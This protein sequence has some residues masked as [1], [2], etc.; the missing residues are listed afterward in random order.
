MVTV[1]VDPRAKRRPASSTLGA[2]PVLPARIRSLRAPLRRL[3]TAPAGRRAKTTGDAHQVRPPAVKLG[4][5]SLGWI[6]ENGPGHPLWLTS[7][8]PP[9][10]FGHR[11]LAP[12]TASRS[13]STAVWP[14]GFDDGGAGGGGGA[15]GAGGGGGAGGAGG[16]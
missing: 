5:G 3:I 13:S 1:K 12:T 10:V 6:R 9:G 14:A 2:V 11:S 8:R 15:G 16:G 7:K 4:S